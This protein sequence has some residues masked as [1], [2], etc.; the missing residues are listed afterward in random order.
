M[1]YMS[2]GAPLLTGQGP[3]THNLRRSWELLMGQGPRTRDLR[4]SW[5]LTRQPGPSP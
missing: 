2:S 3:W 5:E 4:R 1:P